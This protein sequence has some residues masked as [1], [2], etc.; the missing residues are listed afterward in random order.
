MGP[1]ADR[2]HGRPPSDPGDA[3]RP[4]PGDPG[5]E[6]TITVRSGTPGDAA[7]AAALHLGGISDGFLSLLG[8]DFLQR[9]YRRISLHPSAFL[10]VA[11]LDGHTVG[12]IAGA[13]DVPGLYRSFVARDGAAAVFGAIRPLVRGWRRA[14]ETL[15]HGSPA[16]R[17]S[18]ATELLSVAVD[19][20]WQ[21][22]GAARQL[23][24]AF[25]GEVVIRG[26]RS[27]QVV[28]GADN[29]RAVA[30]YQRAGFVV[31]ERF[32]LHPGTDSLLMR[33]EA[34]RGSSSAPGPAT[35]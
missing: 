18:A 29:R 35:G 12:F 25:L 10:L 21:G 11:D 24:A 34:I 6:S 1:N 27:A 13:T 16:G 20:S 3:A 32:E 5:T 2:L 19:P 7:A 14:L 26:G 28:V 22:R 4:T 8:T 30:L 23:V 31:A 15:R 9:L 33:W 17:A